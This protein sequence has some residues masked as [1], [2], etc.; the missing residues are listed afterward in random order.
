MANTAAQLGSG[1]LMA[2]VDIESAYHLIP[3]HPQDRLLQG[4]VWDNRA[5]IDAMLSFGLRSAPKTFNAMADALAWLAQREG[6]WLCYHYLDYYILLGPPGSHECQ[7][8]L[9]IFITL[10]D[11]LGVLLTGHMQ[12]GPTSCLVFLG[13]KIDMVASQLCLPADKIPALKGSCRTRG[14][15]R[16]RHP[17]MLNQ[18]LG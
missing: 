15:G 12:E 3:V 9:E 17:A 8:A 1:T 10:C 5:Y 18:W 13:I 6:V 7:R 4:V 14:R 2:K 16:V 11:H